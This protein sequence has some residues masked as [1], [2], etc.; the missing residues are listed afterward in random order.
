MNSQWVHTDNKC[1]NLSTATGAHLGNLSGATS[2]RLNYTG[3][4]IRIKEVEYDTFG[5]GSNYFNIFSY[6]GTKETTSISSKVLQDHVSWDIKQSY[7]E[8][9]LVNNG[10]FQ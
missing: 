4:I 6:L 3:L 10:F 5:N 1:L 8:I 9:S 2:D 7:T